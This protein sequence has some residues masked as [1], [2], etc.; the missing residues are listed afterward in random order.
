MADPRQL[1]PVVTNEAEALADSQK[2]MG[3]SLSCRAL[4]STNGTLNQLLPPV[5]CWRATAAVATVVVATATSM[6]MA[7][8][9][10]TAT[11]AATAVGAVAVAAVLTALAVMTTVMMMVAAVAAMVVT[12]ATAQQQ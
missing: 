9:M 1:T 10:A 11:A 5:T 4:C 2:A 8:S 6:A 3:T 7:T 12:V